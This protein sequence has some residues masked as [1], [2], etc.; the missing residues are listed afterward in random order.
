MSNN[1][2]ETIMNAM[3][4]VEKQGD[5][6]IATLD[7]M[8]GMATGNTRLEAIHRILELANIV[9]YNADIS[10]NFRKVTKDDVFIHI[11]PMNYYPGQ[12]F[13]LPMYEDIQPIVKQEIKAGE[14]VIVYLNNDEGWVC[15]K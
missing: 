13:F 1:Q 15:R 12:R 2:Q 7:G 8:K 4:T 14:Q 11:A 10:K 3:M 5:S 9:G 6:W